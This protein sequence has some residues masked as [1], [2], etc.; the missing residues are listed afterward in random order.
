MQYY[1]LLDVPTRRA[2]SQQVASTFGD[3]GVSIKS[4]WQEG[5]GDLAQL[6]LITHAARE[7]NV[8]ACIDALRALDVVRD[9]ASLMR[10]EGREV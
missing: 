1:V 3:H 5:E 6:L 8:R 2:C 7:G 9:V 4:V 10:V